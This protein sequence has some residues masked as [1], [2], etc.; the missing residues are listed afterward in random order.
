MQLI[1]YYPK[2]GELVP[3]QQGNCQSKGSPCYSF[4]Q[5]VDCK[6]STTPTSTTT[7]CVVYES[8]PKTASTYFSD[9]CGDEGERETRSGRC[10]FRNDR[11]SAKAFCK[12]NAECVGVETLS[13]FGMQLI[14]YYPK[15]GE[16]VP[17]QQGCQSKWSPCYRF[18]QK[19][20]C[21]K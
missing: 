15:K 10:F 2:K 4:E 1:A 18:E 11:E 3:F 5:K 7:Q 12:K 20:D 16:L 9:E 13:Q 19:V 14:A 17:F 21:A 8:S 6:D